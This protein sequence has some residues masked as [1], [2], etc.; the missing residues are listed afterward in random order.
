VRALV[1]AGRIAAPRRVDRQWLDER[2]ERLHHSDER[3]HDHSDDSH[4]AN[5]LPPLDRL[6]RS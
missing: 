1:F 2:A 3:E 4:E 6:K 5:V